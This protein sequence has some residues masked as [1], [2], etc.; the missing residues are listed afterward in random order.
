MRSLLRTPVLATWVL[1]ACWG[2]SGCSTDTGGEPGRISPP[3][4]KMDTSKLGGPMD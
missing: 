4:G 1:V 3:M 2:S